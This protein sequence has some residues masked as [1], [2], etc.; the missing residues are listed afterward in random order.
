MQNLEFFIQR[1]IKAMKVPNPPH[2]S[3]YPHTPDSRFPN[4][5]YFYNLIVVYFRIFSLLPA[6]CSLF[7][8]LLYFHNVVVVY[9]SSYINLNFCKNLIP[10]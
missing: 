4:F 3:H 1:C 7:P 8:L 6:P 2:T 10:S 5:W 9:L